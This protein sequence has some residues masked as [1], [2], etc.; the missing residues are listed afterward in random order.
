MAKPKSITITEW[1]QELDVLSRPN[2]ENSFTR[3]EV[4]RAL[5]ISK[6]CANVKLNEWRRMGLIEF[7]GKYRTYKN[8]VNERTIPYYRMTEAA[9][10]KLGP[11]FEE[12]NAK[13]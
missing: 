13:P 8:G 2:P 4:E 11:I 12:K 1:L 3:D 7:L 6:G 5:G 9:K 10:A